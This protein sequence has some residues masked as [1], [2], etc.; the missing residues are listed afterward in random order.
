MITPYY[1]VEKPD[2]RH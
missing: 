1:Q 2:Q